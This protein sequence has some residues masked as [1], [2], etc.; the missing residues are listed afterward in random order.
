MRPAAPD[1]KKAARRAELAEKAERAER[2]EKGERILD[3]KFFPTQP[4]LET[5][6]YRLRPL[7]FL[8]PL[9]LQRS[10]QKS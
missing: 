6:F 3:S 7:R 5:L 4:P 10:R 1:R 9:C 2:A 8:C